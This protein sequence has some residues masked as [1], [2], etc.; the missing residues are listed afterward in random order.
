M[1]LD[2]FLCKSTDLT[3]PEATQRIHDGEITVNGVEIRCESTQV[4]ENNCVLWRGQRLK[5]RC[6]RYIAIHKPPNTI[7][8][9]I[10]E[11]YPS[12][13]TGLSI[14]RISELHIVGRLDVDTTGLVLAT[15]NG[16]W[17]FNIITPASQ[18][19]KTYRVGLS[20]PITP[21]AAQR[22][23][24]GLLLQGESQPTQPATINILSPHEVLLSITEGKYHQV[25]RMFATVGNRVVSLHREQIGAVSLDI[26]QGEWRYLTADEVA[27]FP[28][29]L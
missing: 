16:R 6:F 5:A 11:A 9:N 1:R 3:R 27:S 28:Q 23:S 15:D 4:H 17:S 29:S 10:D 2:K 20:R 12:V 25:K 18:C 14:D 26:V 13:F 21:D 22:L 24:Q 19:Q 8:S 7:C